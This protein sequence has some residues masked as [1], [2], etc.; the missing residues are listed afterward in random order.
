[1][2]LV[3]RISRAGDWRGEA[4]V[5]AVRLDR[6]AYGED[7]VHDACA[8]ILAQKRKF[9][10]WLDSGSEEAMANC[11]LILVARVIHMLNHQ[12]EKQGEAFEQ[13]GG[14][15]EKLASIRVEARARQEAAPVCPCCGKAMTRRKAQSGKNAG[16][17]FWGCTGYPDCKGVRE[18][19][20]EG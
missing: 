3:R 16:R 9:A 14:F 15:R 12:M 5:H 6:P 20:A 2:Y 18:I 19:G 11:L 10:R 13:E 17:E 4:K 7:V 8:H 1:M